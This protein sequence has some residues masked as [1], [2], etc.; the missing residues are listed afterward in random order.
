VDGADIPG[1]LNLSDA[2]C[3]ARVIEIHAPYHTTIAAVL[4]ARRSHPPIPI[5]VHSFT[6]SLGGRT[7]P[8]RYGVLHEG[9]SVFALAV[10]ARL[11]AALGAE[12]GENQPYAFDTTDYC[13]P[14]HAVSHGL[15]YLELEVRQDLLATPAEVAGTAGFLKTILDAA[16]RGQGLSA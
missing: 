8:W 16:L 13:A 3:L 6:P 4:E 7:R 11:R 1:N 5:F 14:R 2:D 12:V 10:L 15:Q 9:S